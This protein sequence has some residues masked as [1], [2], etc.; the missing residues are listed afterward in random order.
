MVMRLDSGDSEWL[1]SL[2]WSHK[3]SSL[4]FMLYSFW[5]FSS[6]CPE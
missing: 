2:Y 3:T 1:T 5:C 4:M 6:E